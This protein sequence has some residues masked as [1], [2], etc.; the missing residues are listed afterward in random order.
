MKL[1]II[2][3]SCGTNHRIPTH[4]VHTYGIFV[5]ILKFV[6]FDAEISVSASTCATRLACRARSSSSFVFG[7]FETDRRIFN[8]ELMISASKNTQ[9]LLELP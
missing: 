1:G 2:Q 4:R 5:I 7:E 3:L 8:C 6:A 9:P